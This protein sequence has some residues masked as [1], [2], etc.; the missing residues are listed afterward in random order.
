MI[1]NGYF[2][3]VN[4]PSLAQNLVNLVR[5]TLHQDEYRT[6]NNASNANTHS[7]SADICS[8][9][10]RS[11]ACFFCCCTRTS[12]ACFKLSITWVSIHLSVGHVTV[13]ASDASQGV[14]SISTSLM[15]TV[16]ETSD[17]WG[18]CDMLADDSHVGIFF[19]PC[20]NNL[21]YTFRK[22]CLPVA[23]HRL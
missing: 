13:S 2:C 11:S 21:P 5:V 6:N 8:A 19:I 1:P 9:T 15:G 17:C 22:R 4:C 14:G 18:V 10:L 20:R 23:W 16:R 7:R 12:C 3:C